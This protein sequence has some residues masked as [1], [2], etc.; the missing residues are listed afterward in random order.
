MAKGNIMPQH[1]IKEVFERFGIGDLVEVRCI[2]NK[3]RHGSILYRFFG[4]VKRL[5]QRLPE[6]SYYVE[7]QDTQGK[8]MRGVFHA[9]MLSRN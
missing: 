6:D 5:Q 8:K 3:T 4:E 9:S 1:H 7:G 2:D